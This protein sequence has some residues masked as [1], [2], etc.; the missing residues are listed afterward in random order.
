MI[1]KTKLKK[2]FNEAGLQIT[3]EV[4]DALDHKVD[5]QVDSWV[6]LTKENNVKRLTIELLWSCT[7]PFRL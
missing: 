2:K 1:Q 3:K 7:R 5:K 4:I 6:K